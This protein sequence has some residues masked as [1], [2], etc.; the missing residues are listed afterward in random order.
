[1]D[2][3][4]FRYLPIVLLGDG[5][6][7][8]GWI[9]FRPIDVVRLGPL[10]LGTRDC[11]L[12]EAADCRDDSGLVKPGDRLVLAPHSHGT[13]ILPDMGQKDVHVYIVN[14]SSAVRPKR[15]ATPGVP[16]TILLWG[17][18][19][20]AISLE[21]GRAWG[22]PDFVFGDAVKTKSGNPAE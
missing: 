22:V 2:I 10:I 3:S 4:E 6:A 17:W 15:Y 16:T 20:K 5:V 18:L 8:N 7:P 14:A 12:I 1:M 21:E 11:V 9:A 13:R 19:V